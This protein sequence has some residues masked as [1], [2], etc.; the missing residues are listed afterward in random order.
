MG[1]KLPIPYPLWPYAS[2]YDLHEWQVGCRSRSLLLPT[3]TTCQSMGGR[4]A[5]RRGNLTSRI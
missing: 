5:N 1:S 3:S 4:S 2:N